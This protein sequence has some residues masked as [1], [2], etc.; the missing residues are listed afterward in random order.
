MRLFNVKDSGEFAEYK[1]ESFKS[2]HQEKTL[3]TWLEKNPESI[4]EDGALLIIGRQI[5]TNLGS[6]I[7]LLALDREGNAAILELK[8]DKTPRETIA[9]ALEYASWVE[10]LEFEALEQ[11]LQDYLSNT[12]LSLLEYHRAF[13]KLEDTEGTSFNKEQRIVIVGYDISP[14]IRQT[15]LFLRKKGIRTTCLEFNYFKNTATEQ[16]LTVEIVVGTE[17]VVKGRLKTDS[18][19]TTDKTKFLS[20]LDGYA[21]PVFEAIFAAAES[22]KLPIHWGAI[23]FSLNIDL[24]G[25]HVALVMGYPRSSAYNQTI[26]TYVPSVLT[27]V[28]DGQQLA[29]SFKESLAKTG[30]FKSAGNEMKYVIEQEPTEAQ[31]EALLKAIKDF[32]E[33]IQ[34]K[35]P[36]A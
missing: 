8:R 3:E 6:Y 20:D 1:E 25:N 12:T 32:A 36:N 31:L 28:K 10:G 21:I 30:L 11:I 14:E 7:D 29:N 24:D 27:K 2:E 23:G 34:M 4:V 26:Y 22:R 19:P 33:Q 13:F 17:P 16:L 15:A 5:A 18:R 9:Q 35:G